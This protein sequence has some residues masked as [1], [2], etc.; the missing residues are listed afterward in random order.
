ME[1]CVK[2]HGTVMCG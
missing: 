2:E 1:K